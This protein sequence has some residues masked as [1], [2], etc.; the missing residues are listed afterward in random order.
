MPWLALGPPPSSRDFREETPH[1]GPCTTPKDLS[2]ATLALLTEGPHPGP[3]GAAL[4]TQLPGR[5]VGVTPWLPSSAP[6][7]C[8]PWG[9]VSSSILLLQVTWASGCCTAL[10]E[11]LWGEGTPSRCHGVPS[12]S[13]RAS[14]CRVP[15]RVRGQE[16]HKTQQGS[17]LGGP[18]EAADTPGAREGPDF[19]EVGEGL[20]LGCLQA[21]PITPVCFLLLLFFF[22]KTYFAITIFFF[23]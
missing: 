13:R 20:S 7:C 9:W 19:R 22:F 10:G 17:S 23:F 6:P 2:A 4:G 15:P 11:G 3:W 18:R 12:V 16:P 1:P 5:S 8:L 21:S 14:I